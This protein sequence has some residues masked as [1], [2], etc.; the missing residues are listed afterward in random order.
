MT[1]EQLKRADEV[2]LKIIDGMNKQTMSKETFDLLREFMRSGFIQ[3]YRFGLLDGEV[4]ATKK[5]SE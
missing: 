4:A 3:G 1:E 2:F 5:E